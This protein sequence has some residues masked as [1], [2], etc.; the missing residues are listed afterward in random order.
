MADPAIN[1]GAGSGVAAVEVTVQSAATGQT[2]AT[3]KVEVTGTTWGLSY[4]FPANLTDPSG[5]YTVT[6]T[7]EDK[8]G[9]RSAPL[10]STFELDITG[11][12]VELS[13]LDQARFAIADTITLNGVISDTGASG[14]N[15]F[16][17]QL[18]AR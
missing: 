14:L 16:A 15:E 9:N 5:A 18:P 1:A 10:I 2:Y 6:V 4:Q 12:D 11:P 3:Q 13:Q 8:V 17:D 7:A